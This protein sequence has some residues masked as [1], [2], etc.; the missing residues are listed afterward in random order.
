[1]LT[2]LAKIAEVA[3][4]R[5]TE[6]FTS[7]GHLINEELLEICHNEA[8]GQKATGVDSVTKEEYGR[9]LEANLKD[10]VARLKRHGYH[11]QP[12]RRVYIPKPGSKAK[13]PLG[14]P[15]VCS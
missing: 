9:N 4:T 11:P 6:K 14:I 7:L 2:K 8:K 13:R 12:V 10:L 3:K 15:M 1:M 5:P